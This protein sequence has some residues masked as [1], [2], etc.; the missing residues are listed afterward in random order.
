VLRLEEPESSRQQV[1]KYRGAVQ[2]YSIFDPRYSIFQDAAITSVV[3]VS[4]TLIMVA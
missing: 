1:G 3:C 4:P 2:M